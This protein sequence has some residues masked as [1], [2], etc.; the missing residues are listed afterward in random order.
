M[1]PPLDP[2]L[3]RQVALARWVQSVLQELPAPQAQPERTASS[4]SPEPQARPE[5]AARSAQPAPPAPPEHVAQPAHR[6]PQV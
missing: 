1:T 6:E 3:A 2:E 5:H 4:A